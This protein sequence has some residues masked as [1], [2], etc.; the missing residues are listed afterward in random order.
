[1]TACALNHTIGERKAHGDSRVFNPAFTPR[2]RQVALLEL[3]VADLVDE[4]S[5]RILGKL[6]GKIRQHLRSHFRTKS[7]EIFR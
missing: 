7:I 5:T 2:F 1:M 4:P 3:C 6:F